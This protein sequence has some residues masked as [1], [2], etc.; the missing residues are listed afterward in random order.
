MGYILSC[1]VCSDVGIFYFILFFLM[2]VILSVAASSKRT[3]M[4]RTK[5]QPPVTD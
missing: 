4:K 5:T 1:G 3:K 2:L